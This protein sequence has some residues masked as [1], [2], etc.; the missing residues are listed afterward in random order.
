ME[1]ISCL[2]TW[3]LQALLNW[4]YLHS[5]SMEVLSHLDIWVLWVLRALLKQLAPVFHPQMSSPTRTPG[6]FRLYSSESTLFLIHGGYLPP[7]CLLSFQV[8]APPSPGAWVLQAMFNQ[9]MVVLHPQRLSPSPDAWDLHPSLLLLAQM[10][11]FR[12]YSTA[13][14]PFLIHGGCLLLGHLASLG[15]PGSTQAIPFCSWSS[16]GAWV[17]REAP[18]SSPFTGNPGVRGGIS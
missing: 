5:S 6:F 3:V 1:I 11:G 9:L 10:P 12:L 7:R 13:S 17:L 14:P 15:L 8:S 4:V 16:E 2:D 18:A